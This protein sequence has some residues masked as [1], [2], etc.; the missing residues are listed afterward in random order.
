MYKHFE[1]LADDKKTLILDTC[2]EEFADKGYEL[3]STNLIVKKAGISKGILF[4]YFGN[5]EKL[6]L[7]VLDIA[8]KKGVDRL[9][10]SMENM[11][12]DLFDRILHNQMA[13]IRIAL[14]EPLIYK[15]IYRSFINTPAS[16]RDEIQQRYRQ[17][18]DAGIP[19]FSDGLDVSKIRHDIDPQKAI[20]LVVIFMEGLQGRY[21]EAYRDI[22]PEE[23]YASR[24]KIAEECRTYVDMLKKLIYIG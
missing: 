1:N 10:S 7:Y 13:K 17:L 21:L 14:E 12:V 3:A 8:I 24:N 9:S 5:K 20:D 4:H 19:A 6:Y 11:P 22:S 15:L 18:Y 23:S 16:L 2:M